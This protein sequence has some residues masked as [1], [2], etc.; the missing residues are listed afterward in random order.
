VI[1]RRRAA[2]AR[3]AGAFALGSVSFAQGAA[4]IAADQDLRLVGNGT[5]SA[6]GVFRVAGYRPFLLVCLL[7]AGKGAAAALLTRRLPTGARAMAAGLVIMG[8]NWSPL[9]RGA[10]GRG[11]MP[12]M[13]FLAVT[14]PT[15]AALLAGGVVA[16]Y[17]TGDAAPGCFVA[18]MFLTPLLALTGGRRGALLGAAVAA[19]MLAKRLT[20]NRISPRP[21]TTYWTRAVYDRDRR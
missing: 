20:G 15:G 2:A 10:G 11:V 16:G 1:R 19:P 18:Q 7:D 13:G 6:T 17:V 9:L 21:A 14:H 12:A 5:V 3:L 8:H 4:R